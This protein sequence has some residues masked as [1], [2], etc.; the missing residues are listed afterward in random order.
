MS[1]VYIK[2]LG[3]MPRVG[4][5]QGSMSKSSDLVYVYGLCLGSSRVYVLYPCFLCRI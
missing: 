3:S 5:C 1:R 4:L 2:G